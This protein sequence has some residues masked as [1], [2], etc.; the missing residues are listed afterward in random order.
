MFEQISDSIM[1]VRGKLN[2]R[3]PFSHSIVIDGGDGGAV[4]LDT[5]CG[6]EVIEEIKR[7]YPIRT[8][9]N[10]HGHP[11]HSAGNGRFDDSVTV[12]MPAE[13]IDTGGNIRALADRLAQPGELA[14]YWKDWV[15]KTMGFIDRRPDEAYREGSEFV[16]GNVRLAAI[17]TPG[18]TADHYCL[19]E[20]DRKIL[21]SFDYDLTPFGPWY[22]H[23]ESDIGAF[24]RSI[25]R[26]M[27][28]DVKILVSSHR[29][30]ITE[31]IAEGLSKYLSVFDRREDKIAALLAA[32][33][34]TK[35]DLVEAAPIYGSYPYAEPLL[36]YWEW[37]MIEKHLADL[38]AAGVVIRGGDGRYRT[39]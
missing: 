28:L 15:E 12:Y 39:T 3:F 22:G 11:D 34:R 17:H 4:L 2:G 32:A 27:D 24:K 8:V 10:S 35:D 30:I 21:F 20:P 13:G 16:F 36:R 9:I 37:G 29:D 6:S 26:L 31:G 18:H 19:W 38:I 33:P 23:R 5:G 7:A 1:L 14:A 25:R